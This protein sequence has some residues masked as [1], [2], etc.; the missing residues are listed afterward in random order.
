MDLALLIQQHFLTFD[1]VFIG[2]NLSLGGLLLLRTSGKSKTEV[3]FPIALNGS[4]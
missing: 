1:Q 3:S 2:L 4:D